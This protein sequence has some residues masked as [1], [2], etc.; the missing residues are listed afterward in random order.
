MTSLD[1]PTLS[2]HTIHVWRIALDNFSKTQLAQLTTLLSTDE[3]AR[4]DRFVTTQLQHRALASLSALRIILSRYL[5]CQPTALLFSRN[6]QGKPSLPDHPQLQFN[7]SHSDA[8][9]AC[10]VTLDQSVGIDIEAVIVRDGIDNIVQ[11]F[12]S[13]DEI[14]AWQALPASEKNHAFF[15]MWTRKEAYLKALGLGLQG[16]LDQ[17][18]VEV[19][20]ADRTTVQQADSPESSWVLHN[21]TWATN[22][23]SDQAIEQPLILGSVA[24]NSHMH[25]IQ[26]RSFVLD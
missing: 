11:R 19:S 9:A 24:I 16:G 6:P 1:I 17:F 14:T 22:H 8:W 2:D 13:A 21:L 7:L 5:A 23:A 4:V 20:E 3:Q 10:A 18:S 15:R 25:N 26:T 12:F